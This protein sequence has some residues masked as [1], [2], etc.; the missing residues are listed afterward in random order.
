MKI[1]RADLIQ[2]LAEN[3]GYSKKAATQVVDDF[4]NIIIDNLEGGNIVLL[5]NFGCFDILKREQ[6]SCPNPISGEKI[7]IP[8]HYIP[9]FYPS[10]RMRVAVKK[11]EDNVKRGLA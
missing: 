2:Q 3:Y 10:N 8:A 4:T 1:K 9:R 7:V 11:W 5:R 6:R